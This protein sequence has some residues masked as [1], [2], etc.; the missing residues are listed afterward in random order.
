MV[1]KKLLFQVFATA[2]SILLFNIA[3]AFAGSRFLVSV[4]AEKII[5]HMNKGDRIAEYQVEIRF[6]RVRKILKIPDDWWT[7][8]KDFEE[9][10]LT[11]WAGH[12]AGY[13]TVQ[14][15]T[16]GVFS[17]FIEIDALTENGNFDIR[18]RLTID[19]PRDEDQKRVVL[20]KKSMAIV[21]VKGQ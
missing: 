7:K 10:Q 5:A 3:F 17:N 1:T 2:A 18:I 20:K 11:A 8:T 16:Q 14:D 9:P 6:G 15:I 13:L 19:P 21:P 4:P 12:G